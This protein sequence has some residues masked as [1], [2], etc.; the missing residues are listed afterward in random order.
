MWKLI[1]FLYLEDPSIPPDA[2]PPMREIARYYET[3]AE[4]R[5]QMNWWVENAT[6]ASP[7][8][9]RDA[10]WMVWLET[11]ELSSPAIS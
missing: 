8:E 10:R 6:W 4:C 11:C 5:A 9:A 2:T 7:P 3:E 1:L